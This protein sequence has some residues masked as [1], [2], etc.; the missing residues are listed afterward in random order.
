MGAKFKSP[1]NFDKASF[2]DGEATSEPGA[3][4]RAVTFEN[5]AAFTGVTV[6]TAAKVGFFGTSFK[7][8]PVF[9]RNI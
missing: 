2:E 1:V 6:N 5:E 3:N 8:I 4:F 9:W 7:G